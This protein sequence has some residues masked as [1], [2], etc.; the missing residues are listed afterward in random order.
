VPL[1]IESGVWLQLDELYYDLMRKQPKL[2]VGPPASLFAALDAPAP[3]PW[4]ATTAAANRAD[5]SVPRA[6][7]EGTGSTHVWRAYGSRAES[8][9]QVN[10]GSSSSV[11][12]GRKYGHESNGHD[13]GGASGESMLATEEK[14]P[15]LFKHVDSIGGPRF[16]ILEGLELH[17]DAMTFDEET[18]LI[19]FVDE[20]LQHA[21]PGELVPPT[22]PGR[23]LTLQYGAA[24]YDYS[25]HRGVRA[26]SAGAGP[27]AMPK[28]LARLAEA[29]VVQGIV[30]TREAPDSAVVC[31]YE[32]GE[33]LLPHIDRF[34]PPLLRWQF[35]DSLV[36]LSFFLLPPIVY[37]SASILRVQ[38]ALVVGCIFLRPIWP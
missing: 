3:L 36:F 32:P 14:P 11:G 5:P 24:G 20:R 25:T 10:G 37:G 33:S 13:I 9:S 18:A 29:L 35:Q 7:A 17:E 22:A 6:A 1:V 19:R 4:P 27:P 23:P 26:G 2:P 31:V 34:G 28:E 8:T 12:R 21:V 38:H 16:N 30:G 15:Q